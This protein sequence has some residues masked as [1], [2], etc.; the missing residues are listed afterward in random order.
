LVASSAFGSRISW[1]GDPYRARID[2]KAIYNLRAPLADLMP[3]DSTSNLRRRSPVDLEL[4][5]TS[6]LLSPEVTFDIRLPNADEATK[7][8]LRSILYV[9]QNSVNEQEMNQQV[10][11]LLFLNRFLPPSSGTGQNVGSRGAPGLNNG[12]EMLSNQM[13]NWLSKISDQFDVGVNYRQGDE[14]TG[15]EF[16]LSLSTELFSNRL[17]LDG[18]VGYSNSNQIQNNDQ[19]NFIGEFTVEYK[20]SRDGRLRVSGFNRSVNNNLLQTV[21]PYTQGVGLFYREEFDAF[22]ELWRR[23]FGRDSESK[24][25][26][27]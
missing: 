7:E 3:E 8:R 23:Y 1:D 4:H 5:M 21:S 20:L 15:D 10:F 13:S 11:G 25:P 27:S 22:N 26:D 16:D 12:Y 14:Y 24:K 9:N 2:I 19:S 6:Y 18:N 17:V